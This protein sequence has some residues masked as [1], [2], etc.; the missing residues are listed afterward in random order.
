VLEL[1]EPGTSMEVARVAE[2]VGTT[3]GVVGTSGTLTAG[4]VGTGTRVVGGQV[5]VM[6]LPGQLVTWGGH[7]VMVTVEA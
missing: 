6:V 3:T 1:L 5:V 7:E 4:L 2:G